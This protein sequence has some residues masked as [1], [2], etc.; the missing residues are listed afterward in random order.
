MLIIYH[1]TSY[2]MQ[3]IAGS[4]TAATCAAVPA[5]QHLE[6]YLDLISLP[7]LGV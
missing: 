4:R 7:R 5:A 6:L 1:T 2:I 3:R